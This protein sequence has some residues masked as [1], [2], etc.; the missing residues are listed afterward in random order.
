MCPLW[1]SGARLNRQL[2]VRGSLVHTFD[3]NRMCRRTAASAASAARADEALNPGTHP[4]CLYWRHN[5][6]AYRSC[7]RDA[8]VTQNQLAVTFPGLSALDKLPKLANFLDEG[9]PDVLA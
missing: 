8:V 3:Q 9:E 4:C 7:R 2:D 5:G 1:I 6:S